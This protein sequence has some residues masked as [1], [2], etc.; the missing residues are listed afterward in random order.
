MDNA[1][2]RQAPSRK[3]PRVKPAAPL[4]ASE[5]VPMSAKA[6]APPRLA[7]KQRTAAKRKSKPAEK[8]SKAA[9]KPRAAAPVIALP[10]RHEPLT[11]PGIDL[12]A[13]SALVPRLPPDEPLPRARA[14]AVPRKG[15]LLVAVADWLGSHTRQLWRSLSGPKRPAPKRRAARSE[16]ELLRLRAENER[17]RHQLEAL[18][19]LQTGAADSRTASPV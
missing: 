7:K 1:R 13:W 6:K 5:P 16:D 12:A 9:V 17:L 18:L 19:A 8:R 15:G 14:L 4:P 3:R 10:H 2:N 11:Q